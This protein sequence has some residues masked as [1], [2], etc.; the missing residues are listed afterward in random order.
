MSKIVRESPFIDI[1]RNESAAFA[2]LGLHYSQ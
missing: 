1:Q 2:L